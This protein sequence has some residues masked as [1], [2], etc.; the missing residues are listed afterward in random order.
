MVSLKFWQHEGHDDRSHLKPSVSF[1]IV[2]L[3]LE[4]SQDSDAPL[5]SGKNDRSPKY[6]SQDSD[7]PLISGKND[8]YPKYESA[9]QR[10]KVWKSGALSGCR[11]LG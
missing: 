8:R 1:A 5:I 2:E 7:A 6:E 10:P 3:D 4:M 9:A 11:R